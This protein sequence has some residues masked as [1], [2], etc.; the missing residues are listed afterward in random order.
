MPLHSDQINLNQVVGENIR[1]AGQVGLLTDQN[2]IDATTYTDLQNSMDTN[3]RTAHSDRQGYLYGLKAAIDIGKADGTLSDSAI[4]NATGVDNL[5][6]L[7][8]S[9]PGT[10][11]P[12][13]VG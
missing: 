1:L 8:Q 2:V 7:T 3:A 4:Q 6:S 13:A 5:A 9:A 11:G 12:L 10:I